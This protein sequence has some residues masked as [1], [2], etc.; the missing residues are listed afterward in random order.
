LSTALAARLRT[1]RP[2]DRGGRGSLP[3]A[4]SKSSPKNN[5]RN[6]STSLTLSWA[7]STGATSYEYCVDTTNDNACAGTWISAG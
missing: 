6:Q 2:L 7:S 1:T 4:F 3:G 5:A